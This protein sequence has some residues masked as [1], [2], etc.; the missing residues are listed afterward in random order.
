MIRFPAFQYSFAFPPQVTQKENH[1]LKTDAFT[2]VTPLIRF[3]GAPR[4]L[5]GKIAVCFFSAP[6]GCGYRYAEEVIKSPRGVQE[7]HNKI[8]SLPLSDTEKRLQWN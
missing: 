4:T 8:K 5:V 1:S 6:K 2:Q 7:A 3:G